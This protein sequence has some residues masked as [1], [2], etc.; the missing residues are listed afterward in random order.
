MT[1]NRII[2]PFLILL[3][4]GFFALCFTVEGHKIT[5]P[6]SAV[7]L[8]GVTAVLMI[9]CSFLIAKKGVSASDPSDAVEIDDDGK[10]LVEVEKITRKQLIIRLV[11]FVV[12]VLLFAYLMN[13]LN[14]MIL[15][16]IYL[17]VAMFMLERKRIVISLINSIVIS[18]VFY[19]LFSFVFKIVFP[20]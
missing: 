5:D 18:V 19:F 2:P 14:F 7:F 15:S 4:F 9:I 1:M 16:F 12:V 8:P 10:T 11:L 3:A 20:S 13:Y 17:I 6:T